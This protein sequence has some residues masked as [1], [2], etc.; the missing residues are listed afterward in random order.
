MLELG[1]TGKLRHSDLVMYD[2]TTESWWQQFTG[3][4]IVGELTGSRLAMLPSRLE[5]F[6]NFVERAPGGRVLVA[7]DGGM[8]AYGR[9]PY[10]G[11]D[12][13]PAPFLYRDPLPEQIAP[14][15]RV[16]R[17]DDEAWALDLLRAKGAITTADGPQAHLG[18]GPGL[19]ARSRHD[20]RE[21]RRR[22]RA[23]QRKTAAG[24]EDA[25]YSVDFA[26]P[27][28]HFMPRA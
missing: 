12:T 22:Q 7:G 8:R 2:R 20:R 17:V 28:V 3:E 26:L 23:V 5:S 4:T 6:A 9:N 25:V 1:T 21:L 10:V 18:A 11:Y 16:I 14:R 13:S 19:G 24:W 15:A 27:S